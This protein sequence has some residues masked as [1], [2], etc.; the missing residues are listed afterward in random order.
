VLFCDDYVDKITPGQSYTGVNITA[1]NGTNT[2]TGYTNGNTAGSM[3]NTRDGSANI[4]SGYPTGTTLY[5][6]MAWLA[7]QMMTSGRTVGD[8][9]AIQEAIWSLSENPTTSGSPTVAASGET[10]TYSQWVAD[11]KYEVT[12]SGSLVAGT[13]LTPNYNNWLVL[14]VPADAGVTIGSGGTQELLAYTGQVPTKTPEPAS[15]VLI[16]SGLL[17]A[18]VFGR[19]HRARKQ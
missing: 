16:G 19:R 6:E 18:A 4:S 12:G 13:Y 3:A 14:T 9:E 2:D 11:A 5:E 10:Q 17:M 8:E 15:F 1:A 7:T